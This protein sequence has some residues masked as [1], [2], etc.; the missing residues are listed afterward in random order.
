MQIITKKCHDF[1]IVQQLFIV[2]KKSHSSFQK[3]MTFLVAIYQEYVIKFWYY[4]EIYF[5][6]S[7]LDLIIIII[8]NE[9]ALNLTNFFFCWQFS[10]YAYIIFLDFFTKVIFLIEFNDFYKIYQYKITN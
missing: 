4:C 8:K 7:N 10:F 1:L 3:I 9:N 5:F 2:A 6:L